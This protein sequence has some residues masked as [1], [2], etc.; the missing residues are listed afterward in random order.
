[1]NQK[2][3]QNYINDSQGRLLEA[4]EACKKAIFKTSFKLKELYDLFKKKGYI[5]D[6]EIEVNIWNYGYDLCVNVQKI[7]YENI[8]TDSYVLTFILMQNRINIHPES[9]YDVYFPKRKAHIE[10]KLV[11]TS[12]EQA[13][14]GRYLV[15]RILIEG[16]DLKEVTNGIVYLNN[17]RIKHL[18]DQLKR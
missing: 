3:L 12:K 1:M 10:A 13:E 15:A 9:Y 17:A 4:Q 18:L 16:A 5:E 11:V 14:T 8:P 7:N 6:Y 2:E